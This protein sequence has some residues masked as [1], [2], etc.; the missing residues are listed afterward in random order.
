MQRLDAYN[1]SRSDVFQYLIHTVILADT[2]QRHPQ[3]VDERRVRDKDISTICFRRDAIIAIDDRHPIKVDIIAVYSVHA[4]RVPGWTATVRC[5]VDVDILHQYVLA[6]E[7]CHRPHLALHKSQPCENGITT[8][9]DGKSMWP[10]RIIRHS[11]HEIVPD[12]S[13]AVE[14]PVAVAVEADVVAS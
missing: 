11:L 5:A 10:V 9:P 14:G 2:S 12:L 3:P 8:V 6:F 1:L 13:V 7:D 4:V